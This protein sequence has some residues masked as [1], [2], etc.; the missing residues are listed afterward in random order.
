MQKQLNVYDEVTNAIISQLEA[1]VAPWVKP[2]SDKDAAQYAASD[3]IWP[4]NA[5]TGRPYTGINVILLM[6][7]GP[8]NCE[9]A[10]MTFNQAKKVGASVKAGSKGFRI[11]YADSHVKTKV[12][13][14]GDKEVIAAYSF[15]K[16]H[17]VFHISQIENL[18]ERFKP[19]ALPKADPRTADDAFNLYVDNTRA[20]ITAGGTKAAYA[21]SLDRIAMPALE[22]FR[23]AEDYKATLLHELI[24]WTGHKS[25][26]D[27]LTGARFGSHDYAREELVA[28]MGAAFACAKLGVMGKLQHAEYLAS[29]IKCLKADNKAIFKAAAAAQ[30]AVEFLDKMQT[31]PIP[32]SRALVPVTGSRDLI[33]V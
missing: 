33:P 11:V 30:R 15:L 19:K 27:R 23:T 8:A 31:A 5:T 16:K 9:P 1:G 25:R 18:P 20:T 29:W 6:M 3:E 26:L 17:T 7:F 14:D 32:R 10:Y 21:P 28:E 22:S 13:E 2:W 4:Y 24:H 12:N